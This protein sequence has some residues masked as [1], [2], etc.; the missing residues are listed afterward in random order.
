VIAKADDIPDGDENSAGV[1]GDGALHAGKYNMALA[2]RAIRE[3]WPIPSD[4]RAMLIRQMGRI[5]K[6]NPDARNKIAAAKVLVAADAVNQR[7][8][9]MDQ[10]DEHK[11]LPSLNLHAHMEVP[12]TVFEIVDARA[13]N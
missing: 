13:S 8:E 4:L 7:R 9:A 11:R 10:A 1:L 12:P 5:V 3:D 2:R 6:G